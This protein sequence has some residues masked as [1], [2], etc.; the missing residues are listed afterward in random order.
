MRRAIAGRIDGVRT[1]VMR[2]TRAASG[3]ASAAG[4]HAR[5]HVRRAILALSHALA[6]ARSAIARALRPAAYAAGALTLATLAL[7]GWR[8]MPAPPPP[9]R[10]SA[11]TRPPP[12][13]AAPERTRFITTTAAMGDPATSD[14]AKVALLE[15]IAVEPA[16]DATDVLLDAV[17]SPSLLVSMAG[18]RAL[19][20][21]PCDRVAEAL[22][23]RMAGGEWQ[24]R[25]WAAKVLGENGCTSV[26]PELRRRLAGERDGRVRRQL[27]DALATLGAR[28]AR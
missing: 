22:V 11:A 7:L 14:E 20:G 15:Q 3:R 8:A 27:T 2:A 1:A 6:S 17:G 26:G 4:D 19:R 9:V 28:A 23:Q 25:A 21:R 24:Q 10:A 12:V 18:I 5:A 16:D 13:A